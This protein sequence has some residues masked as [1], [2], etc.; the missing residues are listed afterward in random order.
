MNSHG[1]RDASEATVA[2]LPAERSGSPV[3]IP[4]AFAIRASA[5]A[6]PPI[7]GPAVRVADRPP[8]AAASDRERLE[9]EREGGGA[10]AQRAGGPGTI[11][12]RLWRRFRR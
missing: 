9:H 4:G 1:V 3:M 2:V 7:Q 5:R 6:A 10:P 12:A 11:G 8:A